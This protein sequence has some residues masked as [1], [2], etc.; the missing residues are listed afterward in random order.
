MEIAPIIPTAHCWTLFSDL[1]ILTDP[2][3]LPL[4]MGVAINGCNIDDSCRTVVH[5]ICSLLFLTGSFKG[6]QLRTQWWGGFKTTCS[7]CGLLSVHRILRALLLNS[8]FQSRA[9][10]FIVHFLYTLECQAYRWQ[11]GRRI[12]FLG[13]KVRLC[14]FKSWLLP[15]SY[16]T[17]ASYLMSNVLNFLMWTLLLII[18]NI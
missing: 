11:H 9:C 16:M 14:Q 8:D 7:S 2:N 12:K 10:F 5:L 4:R 15:L 17:W 18:I 6:I 3:M 1:T 13:P